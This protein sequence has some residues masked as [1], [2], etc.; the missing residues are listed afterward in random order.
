[1]L[2]RACFVML[3]HTKMLKEA[4]VVSHVLQA[5]S[6]IKEASP[7]LIACTA[8][9]ESTW[10]IEIATTQTTG[11]VD[12]AHLEVH[13]RILMHHGA[14]LA[15]CSAG[16]RFLRKTAVRWSYLP[17]VS[18]HRPASVLATRRS[19]TWVTLTQRATISRWRHRHCRSL[20]ETPLI[21]QITDRCRL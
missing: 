19:S 11:G 12:L 18:S 1:M 20:Q 2:P 15:R 14:I 13:V 8:T 10:T 16:G 17:P 5:H 6:A 21:L 4:H 3:A 7:L 9:N